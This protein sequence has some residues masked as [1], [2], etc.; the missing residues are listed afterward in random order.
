M[1]GHKAHWAVVCGV[2]EGS[3]G[4]VHVAA[5]HGKSRY[6]GVW[7]L[8]SLA[9]SNANLAELDPSRRKDNCQYILPSGGVRAGLSNRYILITKK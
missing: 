4:Q 3:D 8:D 5:R 2:M 9:N 1:N 7:S 6:L